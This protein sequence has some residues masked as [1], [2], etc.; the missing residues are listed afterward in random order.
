MTG[1]VVDNLLKVSVIQKL[2]LYSLPEV[3]RL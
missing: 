1:H 2:V 3:V